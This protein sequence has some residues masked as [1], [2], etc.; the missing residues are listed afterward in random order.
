MSLIRSVHVHNNWLTSIAPAIA[1]RSLAGVKSISFGLKP[2]FC[3]NTE[4][5][6]SVH[7]AVET[8]APLTSLWSLVDYNPLHHYT[9]SPATPPHQPPPPHRTSPC[10]GGEGDSKQTFYLQFPPLSMHQKVGADSANVQC[11]I[12]HRRAHT[13]CLRT[14][15]SPLHSR[16]NQGL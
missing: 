11:D 15:T 9:T 10:H 14:T 6:G 2:L 4:Q 1:L 3:M 13:G 5:G 12:N 7:L 8:C 16:A